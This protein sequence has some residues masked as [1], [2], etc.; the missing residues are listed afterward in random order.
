MAA[1]QGTSP[2]I[3][4]A[5][6]DRGQLARP[7]G[8]N[9]ALVHVTFK[10]QTKSPID[11]LII[12]YTDPRGSVQMT[13][14]HD[15]RGFGIAGFAGRGH[16]QVAFGAG[17]LPGTHQYRLELVDAKNQKSAAA[18]FSIEIA[19][20]GSP[21]LQITGVEPAS[22]SAGDKVVLRGRGFSAED[23]TVAVGSV[24]AKVIEATGDSLV[25]VVPEGAVTGPISIMNKEGV[26]V[27][28]STFAVHNAM[29]VIGDGRQTILPG[30]KIQFSARVDGR[31][32]RSVSWSVNGQVGG[33]RNFGTIDRS[34]VYVAPAMPPSQQ[35]VEISATSS[36][37][38]LSSKTTITVA[39]GHPIRPGE[40]IAAGVGGV[41]RYE[42]GLLTLEIPP[43]SLA[44]DANLGT[45]SAKSLP[46]RNDL[47]G[48]PA[49]SLPLVWFQSSAGQSSALQGPLRFRVLLP[50]RV[51]AGSTHR[52]MVRPTGSQTFQDAGTAVADKDG[53]TATGT[54]HVKS[55]DFAAVILQNPSLRLPGAMLPLQVK[56]LS[57]PP[58][59]QVYEGMTLPVR[60]AGQGFVPGLT[61]VSAGP[62]SPACSSAGLDLS[63]FAL[64]QL[65]D[66]GPVL[67]KPNG[68]QLGFTLR[69]QPMHSLDLTQQI[70]FSFRIDRRDATGAVQESITT[71][72]EGFVVNGLP[73]LIVCQNADPA[74]HCPAPEN[75]L[76]TVDGVAVQR[77]L[78][79]PE[80]L[81]SEVR[82]DPGATLG[83]GTPVGLVQVD[84]TTVDLSTIGALT[85]SLGHLTQ[86][87]G[88]DWV[89][90]NSARI[91]QPL[92]SPVTINVTGPVRI[93]G[94][95]YLRGMHGGEN[96]HFSDLAGTGRLGGFASA[97]LSG[98]VGGGGGMSSGNM[99]SDGHPAG[100]NTDLA[101]GRGA[102]GGLDSGQAI[103]G[104]GSR[105]DPG[106]FS[107]D[108][109][110][111]TELFLL[112]LDYPNALLPGGLIPSDTSI[113]PF[114]KGVLTRGN[115][116]S[117]TGQAAPSV[118]QAI[119]SLASNTTSTS[120]YVSHAG[121]GGDGGHR[122]P[123]VSAVLNEDSGFHLVPGSGGAGGGGGGSTYFG[124][125]A[126]GIS[127]GGDA[128]T[129]G[130]GGGGGGAAGALKINSS[131]EL[132]ITSSG[133]IDAKGGRG[134]K[135][136][137]NWAL[138]GPGGGGGGGAGGL[139][140]LQ[141]LHL[142]NQGVIDAS[143][144]AL[145]GSPTAFNY[146][147]IANGRYHIQVLDGSP[148][149]GNMVY[150][151]S[152]FIGV[153][154]PSASLLWS[155][156]RL[157]AEVTLPFTGIRAIGKG[158]SLLDLIFGNVNPAA[159]GPAPLRALL[160]I[161]DDDRVVQ[162]SVPE[163]SSG[164][165]QIIRIGELA[166]L[167]SIQQLVGFTPTCVT[168]SPFPPFNI[169]IGGVQG[170]GAE[171]VANSRI[172]EFDSSGNFIR[173]VF[174]AR[175]VKVWGGF[176]GIGHVQDLDFL[177]DGRLVG[178]MTLFPPTL[179]SNGIH[180]IDTNTG[181]AS[182]M[183]RGDLNTM[184]SM[185]VLRGVGSDVFVVV[186]WDPTVDT[187]DHQI[188]PN[189]LK[190]YDL[191]GNSSSPWAF[192]V[193]TLSSPGDPGLVRLDGALPGSNEP[194]ITYGGSPL[195]GTLFD[196]DV[197][198]NVYHVPAI[199]SFSSADVSG[200]ESLVF[201][202]NS[203]PVFCQG[204]APGAD[205][206]DLW[207]KPEAASQMSIR[208]PP[209][210]NQGS[211]SGSLM[212]PEGFTSVW[213]QTSDSGD[214][215]DW[216]KQAVLVISQGSS[217]P[218]PASL[219]IS[220][221]VIP[222]S[223]SALFAVQLD[224]VPF[225]NLANGNSTGPQTVPIGRHSLSEFGVLPTNSSN[226]TIAFGGDC[227]A[228]GTILLNPGDAKS[229]TITSTRISRQAC[230][231]GCQSDREE[232]MQSGDISP[233][234][235]LSQYQRCVA[236]CNAR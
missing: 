128:H 121:K 102:G 30:R 53:I 150:Y 106:V 22:G 37:T 113:E 152:R 86:D 235:C 207:R 61:F 167:H 2:T 63:G 47:N 175:T 52:V 29:R 100:E 60:I 31:L 20:N 145:A 109:F 186:T 79:D 12:T 164:N 64:D 69:I 99:T 211:C 85:G 50:S 229:C 54:L 144:G 140:K 216:L 36:A 38:K 210:D 127:F 166:D 193:E 153:A 208:I 87:D 122:P 81:F 214:A 215:P 13:T 27:S 213:V 133:S 43:A 57:T 115:V 160:V 131:R 7:A 33:S 72:P 119:A 10:Y 15:V 46:S 51:P 80:S 45:I 40:T 212:L 84:T 181:T 42:G 101:R 32:D 194:Q 206:I 176:V 14:T 4:E 222:A 180:A 112:G 163:F 183:V 17:A 168:Q 124:Y 137:P 218:R 146:I 65:L 56:Q 159:P 156:G 226:Y 91:L 67:V 187:D 143:G 92:N 62:A 130:G 5:A 16:Y 66:F 171:P 141:S 11:S 136:E 236:Q 196:P 89:P 24:P 134:G 172:H 76:F 83:I 49:Q 18:G 132:E 197:N 230:V 1:A 184:S 178:M 189:H 110:F 209:A 105:Y 219:T 95:V 201:G 198:P 82:I 25:F 78:A 70:C 179:F 173:T 9:I 104:G 139:L 185:S 103:A 234:A 3:T 23:T 93:A 165:P 48:V 90:D 223:A 221:L 190:H 77:A 73:E 138:G 94:N 203:I 58:D 26:A 98:G 195:T 74:R 155:N 34:G 161:T 169:Y 182:L 192:V 68:T 41:V 149:G 28:Q 225:A 188:Q 88:S 142:V 125:S 205:N 158:L 148:N 147:P 191:M 228:D 157:R 227:A 231:A 111:Q 108:P 44:R 135:G 39:A 170:S 71:R 174:D 200:L 75:H 220:Q 199:S 19:E 21:A 151:G 97:L 232:C 233:A 120:A 59:T 202:Q 96:P 162:A 217:S 6:V 118:A 117:I 204:A 107:L 123:S 224:G 8:S 35:T 126:F 55:L 129:G 114:L 177:S 116:T 154:A